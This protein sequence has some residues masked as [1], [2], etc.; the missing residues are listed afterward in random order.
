MMQLHRAKFN[1][2]FINHRPEENTGARTF[3]QNGLCV[4]SSARLLYTLAN[5][6]SE[7]AQACASD[8]TLPS[9]LQVLLECLL[10]ISYKDFWN[11]PLH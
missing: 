8:F 1:V 7:P 10:E 5:M 3:Q 4:K 6:T 11:C 9:P 2:K